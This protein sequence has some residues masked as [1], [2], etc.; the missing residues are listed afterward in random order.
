MGSSSYCFSQDLGNSG[1]LDSFNGQL[2]TTWNHLESLDEGQSIADC[3]HEH[4]CILVTLTNVGRPKLGGTT[5]QAWALDRIKEEKGS[6]AHVC[7][8][9]FP[10]LPAVAVIRFSPV[11]L[12]FPLIDREGAVSAESQPLLPSFF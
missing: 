10:L 12:A 2:H 8:R 9:S 6:R 3:P 1:M 7:V 4:A 11:A 5:C